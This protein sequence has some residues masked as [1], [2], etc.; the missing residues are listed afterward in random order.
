MDEGK[1]EQN[2]KLPFKFRKL[3]V[4]TSAVE[5][6]WSAIESQLSNQKLKKLPFRIYTLA[7]IIS[8]IAIGSGLWLYQS[9]PVEIHTAYGE[10]RRVVLPD[11]SVVVLNSNSSIRIP[12]DW[13]MDKKR[14]VW[15]TG[16][17]FFEIKKKPGTGS[18]TFVVHT[19][20]VDVQVLGTKFNVNAKEEQAVV[21]LKEGKVRLRSKEHTPVETKELDMVP[22]DVVEIKGKEFT[23][24]KSKDIEKISGWRN[25][26][27]YFHNTPIAEIARMIK[28]KYGYD[29]ELKDRNLSDKKLNGQLN[30]ANIHEFAKALEVALEIDIEIKEKALIIKSK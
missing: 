9:K 8:F 29:V 27:F 3:N 20:Q 11:A 23:I 5:K 10:V 25:N 12:K 17:G 7:A 15:L 4:P 16:E 2:Y 13:S 24:N 18:A 1:P 28:D 30:A 26:R 21:A 6:S 14:E 22:G 19:N